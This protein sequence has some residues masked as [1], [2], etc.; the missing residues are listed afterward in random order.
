MGKKYQ[1]PSIC[2][3]NFRFAVMITMG[4]TNKTIC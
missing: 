3:E 2:E 1:Q 4:T